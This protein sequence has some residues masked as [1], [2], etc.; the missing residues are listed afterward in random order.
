[1]DPLLQIAEDLERRDEQAEEALL[2]VERLQAEVD[3]LRR[4]AGAT[5]EFLRS[6]PDAHAGLEGDERAAA[7]AR[8]AA[9][10]AVTEAQAE[11]EKAKNDAERLAA[12]RHVQQ[13]RDRVRAAELWGERVRD[14]RLRLE[15]EAEER[16]RE[17][18][19]LEARAHDLA[20][21][22][23]LARAVAPPAG[24]LHGVLD[25]GS[26]ARGELL[27]AHAGLASER[28][29][30]VREASELVASVLGE[31]LT[32]TRVAGVRARLERALGGPSA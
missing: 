4:H 22:P 12:E 27:V 18:G 6:Y 8:A 9:G 16:Q 15:G 25:W 29:K 23:R 28:D 10:G 14:D 30:V 7:E 2:A 1:M 20:A 32:A 5:A 13:A 26:R 24:G 17:A 11:L 3:E 21:E 19:R 31:P